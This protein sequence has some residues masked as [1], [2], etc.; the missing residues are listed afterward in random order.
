[1]IRRSSKFLREIAAHMLVSFFTEF[2]KG[3]CPDAPT[4]PPTTSFQEDPSPQLYRGRSENWSTTDEEKSQLSSRS[5]SPDYTVGDPYAI[6][7]KEINPS[8]TYRWTKPPL[9]LQKDPS[10]LPRDQRVD[11]HRRLAAAHKAPSWQFPLKIISQ[12]FSQ[13]V[14]QSVSYSGE[15]A[16]DVRLPCRVSRRWTWV[17][18][19]C[20]ES[21]L[22]MLDSLAVWSQ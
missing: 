3:S 22:L 4:L 21:L 20:A 6:N 8:T 16:A 5:P 17:E 19:W 10:L 18:R 12:S 2:T 7:S 14:S 11:H 13:S 9:N 1:M 15:F